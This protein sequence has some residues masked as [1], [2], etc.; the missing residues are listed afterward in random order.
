MRFLRV[1]GTAAGLFAFSYLAFSPLALADKNHNE[2]PKGVA[3]DA[4]YSLRKVDGTPFKAE[5]I[6]GKPFV[7]FFG[8]TNCPDICPT[9][10]TE[11]SAHLE[12]LGADG[13]RIKVLFVT[14]D[15]ERDTDEQLK[16]YMK[17]FDP[18]I[19]ALTGDTLSI[20][21]VAQAFGAFYEKVQDENGGYTIDHTKRTFLMDKYGL[22]AMAAPASMTEAEVV[23]VL[24][25]L[26]AQ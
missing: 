3:L 10:L 17:S 8:F 12:T 24:R 6:K 9:T 23:A 14:V 13:D 15:P 4:L 18:R 11:M 7:V 1:F 25:K 22:L 26:L 2:R 16:T 21:A 5:E 19:T 20:A